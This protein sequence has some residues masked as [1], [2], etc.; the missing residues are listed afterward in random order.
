M[1]EDDVGLGEEQLVAEQGAHPLQIDLVKVRLVQRALEAAQPL[2]DL[3]DFALR[4]PVL[5]LR[6]LLMLLLVQRKG[7]LL[8]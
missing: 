3:Q 2:E 1:L 5:D 6:V 4:V 8:A 7:R